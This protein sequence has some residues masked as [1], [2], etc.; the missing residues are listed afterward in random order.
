MGGCL[1]KSAVNDPIFERKNMANNA[2]P[3]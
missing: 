3:S 1:R 2:P